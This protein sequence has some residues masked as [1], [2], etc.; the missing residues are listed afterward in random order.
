[1]VK[2]K[3]VMSYYVQRPEEVD[4]FIRNFLFKLGWNEH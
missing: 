2:E 1:M 4:D 3:E